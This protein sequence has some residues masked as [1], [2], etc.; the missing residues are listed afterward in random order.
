MATLIPKAPSK[1]K[2][3]EPPKNDEVKGNLSAPSE[4]D[5]VYLTF[6]VTSEYRKNFKITAATQGIK[7][8]DLFFQAMD[9]WRQRHD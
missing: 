6:R 4:N 2:K 3:G 9:E 7:Q 5:M 1:S 8:V